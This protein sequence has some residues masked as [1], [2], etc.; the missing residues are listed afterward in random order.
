[1]QVDYLIIGQGISGSWLSYFL[2][3]SN[4]S[5]L[6]I[7]NEFENSSSRLAGGVINPI[8][9]RILAKTWMASELITFS[10]QH[11]PAMAHLL[12]ADFFTE[13]Q[14]DQYIGTAQMREV[15]Q[16]R[17]LELPEYISS[18]DD[19]NTD[20][21]F[22]VFLA[23]AVIKPVL[24]IDLKKMLA[25]WQNFLLQHKKL[26]VETF[27]EK[28]LVLTRDKVLYNGVTAQNLIYC[29]G[30]ASLSS[31]FWNVL[32]LVPNKGE[33]LLV[34]I[35][36]LPQHCIYK[37]NF[38]LVP[39]GNGVFWMGS[40]YNWQFDT[41]GPTP[42]FLHNCTTTLN[43]WLKIPYQIMEHNAAIRPASLDRRPFVGLHPHYN[44]I[45]IFNGMGTKGCSLAPFFAN[46][47]AN[48][49]TNNEPLLPD[50]EVNRYK[51]LLVKTC[52]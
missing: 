9:G 14:I 4:A 18:V 6:V 5:Y 21:Y 31:K 44:N 16:K 36:D 7:D 15:Y 1:M 48:H 26:R 46:A 17:C 8:T 41:D 12:N 24:Q 20:I 3:A 40:S 32:P 2:E 10:K 38:T 39:Q 42:Q 30:T 25:A 28:E 35:P 27:N 33:F 34:N 19:A 51:K 13:T 22:N 23:K 37:S 49:L 50:V 29:D 52:N 45:G 43:Q 47:F 11:Y